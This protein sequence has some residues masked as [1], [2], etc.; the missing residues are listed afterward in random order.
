MNAQAIDR[1]N[2]ILLR[3]DGGRFSIPGRD[4]QMEA[5]WKVLS[6]PDIAKL[7]KVI[8]AN[9]KFDGGANTFARDHEGGLMLFVHE[10]SPDYDAMIDIISDAG[11]D[12]LIDKASLNQLI[13]VDAENNEHVASH[14]PAFMDRSSGVRRISREEGM[15]AIEKMKASRPSEPH[16]NDGGYSS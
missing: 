1:T 16:N 9:M 8:L 15:A 5:F 3:T 10:G 11:I 13:T 6:G 2:N 4:G 14:V 7:P 12:L